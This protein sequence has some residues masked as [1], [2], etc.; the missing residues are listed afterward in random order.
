MGRVA[1]TL[2]HPT[3]HASHTPHRAALWRYVLS[4]DAATALSAPAVYSLLLPFAMLD[5]WVSLYQAVCFRAWG[6]TRVCRSEF[7]RIDRERLPYL[8]GLEKANCLYCSYANGVI[9]FVREVAG[10]TEQYWCPIRH[11]HP[12]AE[13]H[14]RYKE[15]VAYGDA[16]G[17]RE[18][19]SSL[20]GQLRK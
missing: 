6:I 2:S 3:V 15:F 20:R 4:A 9:A 12:V 17:Y 19:L 8:N 14:Q 11:A 13:P 10:R 18:E 7:F 1:H 5:L 16:A